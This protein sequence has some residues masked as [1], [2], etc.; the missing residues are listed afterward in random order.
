MNL[1]QQA[2]K[3]RKVDKLLSDAHSLLVDIYDVRNRANSTL[4]GDAL[5][6][7]IAQISNVIHVLRNCGE[8]PDYLAIWERN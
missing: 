2:N 5:T 1:K 4:Y 6:S 7:S 3:M 8:S